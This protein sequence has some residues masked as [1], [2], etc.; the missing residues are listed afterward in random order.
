MNRAILGVAAALATMPLTASHAWS[1]P[2]VTASVS[3]YTA[4]GFNCTVDGLSFSDFSVT[5]SPASAIASATFSPVQFLFN[6]VLESGL[7]LSYNLAVGP[8]SSGD[9]AWL[10]NVTAAAGVAIVDAYLDYNA[11]VIGSG[12]ATI[13]EKLSNGANLTLFAPNT[14]PI[15]AN[16]APVFQLFASKDQNDF[17]PGDGS[18]TSSV[19]VNAFST[20]PV[21]GPVLGAG[22]PALVASCGALIGLARRRRRGEARVA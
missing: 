7:A 6:G 1:S 2:C 4:S 21:P 16:F 11:T 10:Y 17:V 13:T 19:M 22:F 9:V 8:G 15:T 5:A 20:V 3:T 14:G 18:S 12:L